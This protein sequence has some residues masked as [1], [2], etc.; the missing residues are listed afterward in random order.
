MPPDDARVDDTRAWLKRAAEDLRAADHVLAA[1]P[2]LLGDAAFHCQQ[3]V[4][5]ALKALLAWNDTP[6]R[7]T[8]SL[9]ELGEAVLRLDGTL[10]S[11]IDRAAVLSEDAWKYR[12]PGD[13]AEPTA[14]E[15]R[16]AL[17]LAREVYAAVLSRLPPQAA[18]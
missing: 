4:E 17:A 13:E 18:P 7:K 2:P 14:E 15:T 5:K 6:F 1:Q 9:E 11:V 3:T 8:H 12:Y 10:H 16:R